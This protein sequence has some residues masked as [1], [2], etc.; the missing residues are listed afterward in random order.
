VS[1]LLVRW[2]AGLRTFR[3]MPAAQIALRGLLVVTG[4]AGFALV[5]DRGASL[6]GIAA[7][8]GL[9]SAPVA[10]VHPGSDAPSAVLGGTAIAW[11]AGYGGHLPPAA[12]TVLLGTVLYVHHLVATLAA[13]APA[14]AL[15]DPRLAGRWAVPLL[16]GLAA[17][18]AAAVAGYG[19]R[20]VPLSPVLQIAGLAGV[21]ATAGLL[22]LLARR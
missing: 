16:V 15:L 8:I 9:V 19:T 20:E 10:A 18:G 6:A 14:T 4:V 5:P 2:R 17:L 11:V 1:R 13:A 22:A 21:L 3:A 12:A 7:W